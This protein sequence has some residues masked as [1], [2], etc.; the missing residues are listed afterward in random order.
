MDA[1]SRLD[2]QVG[3]NPVGRVGAQLGDPVP[4]V[5]PQG[6]KASGSLFHLLADLPP[7]S[8]G[9]DPAF[10][11]PKSRLFGAR[12]YGRRQHIRYRLYGCRRERHDLAAILVG[13][14]R[15]QIL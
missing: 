6:A 5:Q 7:S 8:P 10:D 12:G 15:W 4:A 13:R 11:S 9:E 14:Y 1:A 3:Q 2:G